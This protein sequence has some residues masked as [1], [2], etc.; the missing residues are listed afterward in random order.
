[1]SYTFKCNKCDYNVESTGEVSV[2]MQA[3]LSPYICND[4]NIITD[5][6]VGMSGDV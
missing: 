5:V 2:G 4:C 1:M 6:M 3:V